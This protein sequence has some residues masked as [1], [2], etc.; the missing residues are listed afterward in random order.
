MTL[1]S[2]FHKNSFKFNLSN[3][4]QFYKVT[5][6]RY[7]NQ[8]NINPM[9]YRFLLPFIQLICWYCWTLFILWLVVPKAT[10]DSIPLEFIHPHGNLSTSSSQL[11]NKQTHLF[12]PDLQKCLWG[13]F[14]AVIP[15]LEIQRNILGSISIWTRVIL[16]TGMPVLLLCSRMASGFGASYSQ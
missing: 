13:D 6:S 4:R 5:I 12:V 7:I 2:S 8:S 9:R 10:L 15:N 16:S 11:E 1:F 14:L 3:A